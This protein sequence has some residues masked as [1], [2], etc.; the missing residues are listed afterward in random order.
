[1][2]TTSTRASVPSG[3]SPQNSLNK[4]C[5][6]ASHYYDFKIRGKFSKIQMIKIAEENLNFLNL[7]QNFHAKW[8]G[9]EG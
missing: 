2:L 1:V 5:R 6:L 7:P 4:F 8:Q 9:G 3:S